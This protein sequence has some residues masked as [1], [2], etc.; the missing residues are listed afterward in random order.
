M[1]GAISLPVRTLSS[2]HAPFP[3]TK[4]LIA[5]EDYDRHILCTTKKEF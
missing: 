5:M 4:P 3:Q 2:A 1:A